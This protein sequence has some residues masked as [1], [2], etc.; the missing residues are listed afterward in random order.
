M[1]ESFSLR[2]HLCPNKECVPT[3]Q[4][5]NGAAKAA[6]FAER[7]RDSAQP[8]ELSRGAAVDPSPRQTPG[9]RGLLIKTHGVAKEALKS[10]TPDA[11]HSNTGPPTRGWPEP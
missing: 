3:R 11:A 6:S 5:T 9:S 10:F 8:Q 1:G 2:E 7:K 4:E